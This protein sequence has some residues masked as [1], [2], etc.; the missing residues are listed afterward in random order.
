MEEHERRALT[1]DGWQ[2]M[3]VRI[4]DVSSG[5]RLRI[6]GR[7]DEVRNRVC[8]KSTAVLV[9]TAVADIMGCCYQRECI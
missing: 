5:G 3:W 2:E 8:G 9:I 4:C 1:K 7:F 6:G